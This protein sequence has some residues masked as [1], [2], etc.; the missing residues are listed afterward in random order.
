MKKI[1]SIKEF[2]SY[3][4]AYHFFWIILSFIALVVDP[5][6]PDNYNMLISGSNFKILY[7]IYSGIYLLPLF[8]LISI[9]K[10]IST[11]KILLSFVFISTIT[12]MML[13]FQQHYFVSFDLYSIFLPYLLTV[14]AWQTLI[15]SL[16][17][18]FI[19]N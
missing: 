9:N 19:K 3:C 5:P 6:K 16:G 4:A 1:H 15:F 18:Y 17:L 11:V 14:V 8:L 13:Y 10:Q 12:F 7:F 2:V